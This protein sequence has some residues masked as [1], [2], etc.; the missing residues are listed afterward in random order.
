MKNSSSVEKKEFVIDSQGNSLLHNECKQ[1]NLDFVCK[2]NLAEVGCSHY[3]LNHDGY[4]PIHM[5]VLSGNTELVTWICSQD[6][7]LINAATAYGNTPLHIA[8]ES[9]NTEMMLLLISNGVTTTI[10]NNGGQTALDV[11]CHTSTQANELFTS[12]SDIT[13]EDLLDVLNSI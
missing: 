3:D 9:A 5:A 2:V 6:S 12:N 4:Y 8:A 13:I 11:L 10:E 1:G 7:E